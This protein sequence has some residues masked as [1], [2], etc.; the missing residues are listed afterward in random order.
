MGLELVTPLPPG[1]SSHTRLARHGARLVVLREIKDGTDC[2]WPPASPRLITLQEVGELQGKRHA[3]FEW[4]PGATLRETLRALEAVGNPIPLGLVGRVLVD[5]ARALEGATPPRPH[6]GLQDAAMQIGFDGVVSVLDWGAPRISRFRP[7][8][9]V[10]FAA[11]VFALGGVLHS[12]LTGFQGDYATPASTLATPSNSHPEATPAIDDIVQRALSPQPDARQADAGSFADELEAVL[13]DTL[14]TARQLADVVGTLFKDRIKLLQSLGGLMEPSAGASR[15]AELP[16]AGIPTGTQPGVG[17]GDG[18]SDRTLPRAPAPLPPK[19]MVPWESAVALPATEPTSEPTLPRVISSERVQR[20]VAAPNP[21]PPSEPTL[22]RINSSEVIPRASNPEP[23]SEPTL[24]RINSSDVVPRAKV[25]VEE[26]DHDEGVRTIAARPLRS[27]PEPVTA[28][29][30]NPRARPELTADD[31]NPRAKPELTADDTNPRARPEQLQDT[32]PQTRVPSK[33]AE[34]ED[35]GPQRPRRPL[36]ADDLEDTGPNRPRNTT[37]H[38]RLRARGQERVQ[39]PPE[40]M[41]ALGDEAALDEPTAVRKKPDPMVFVQTAQQLPPVPDEEE[42]PE[43]PVAAGGGGGGALRV[44][45]VVLLLVVVGIAVAVVLKLK[46]EQERQAALA[47]QPVVEEDAGTVVEEDA[48]ALAAVVA[49]EPDAGF[50]DAGE[51]VTVDAGAPAE[52]DAGV[53][54]PDAGVKPT[55]KP[56]VKKPPK[57]KKKKR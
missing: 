18:Q 27:R 56:P 42:A 7:L 3:L 11:D 32:G 33:P 36:P 16:M 17:G 1:A 8:G 53:A 30:T 51:D 45:M 19:P 24:P 38:E 23:P 31:T 50:V 10:N 41:E 46:R 26:L 12:A 40:G 48:G 5:A 28:E 49:D 54:A 55:K 4:V 20:V 22:P 25:P 15:E 47:N 29:D 21:E 37:T 13:G 39:T 34:L 44:V 57:K 9:R 6:G 14:F 52:V 43:A 35:T 2:S